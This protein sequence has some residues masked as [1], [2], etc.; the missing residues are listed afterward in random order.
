LRTAKTRIQAVA[1]DLDGLMF[2]TEELYNEVG[3]ELVGR[4]GF[5]IDSELLRQMM[6]RP[7]SVALPLMIQWY[8]LQVTV[9]QLQVE[10]DE[11][12]ATLLE[13]RLQTMPGLVD[14]LGE[15]DQRRI[16]KAI[17]T[18][19]RREYVDNVLR[20]AGLAAEFSLILS[21][22]DVTHGKPAPEIYLKAADRMAVSPPALLVLEDSE[23][24]CRAGVAA[25]AFTVA[26]PGTHSAEH[27]FPGVA[28]VADSLRDPR[29]YDCLT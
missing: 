13:Q 7:S 16:P 23:I 28:F 25:N 6:G 4:R 20:I 5:Q 22:E 9:E 21:A 18:S 10:T 3:A 14:L 15:L 12:F 29:I 1:F 26:V 11:I 8:G 24:G 19:S 17:T 27:E 2:N